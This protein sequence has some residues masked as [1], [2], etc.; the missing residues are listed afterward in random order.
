MGV[1]PALK[2]LT[3]G[4]FVVG[5][6][7]FGSI[8]WHLDLPYQIGLAGISGVF[9]VTDQRF[10]QITPRGLFHRSVADLGLE[11]NR[12]VNYEVAGLQETLTI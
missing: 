1:L 11:S 4:S 7:K 6:S 2:F 9:I 3:I 8:P 12:S 5:W 10:I